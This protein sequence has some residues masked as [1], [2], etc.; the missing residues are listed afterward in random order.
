MKSR[1]SFG[2]AAYILCAAPLAAIE[3]DGLAATV[4]DVSILRSDVIDDM[5]RA[6]ATAS[7]YERYHKRLIDRQI[8]LKAA[9]KDK[10]TM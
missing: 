4:G 10:V 2:V 5:R 7:E 9:T 6:G 1:F 8:I 3:V